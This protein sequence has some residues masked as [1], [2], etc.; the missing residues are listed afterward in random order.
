MAVNIYSVKCV[1]HPRTLYRGLYHTPPTK[2][3]KYAQ[4]QAPPL[5]LPPQQLDQCCVRD[6]YDTRTQVQGHAQLVCS[7]LME[8]YGSL[9][10]KVGM[11]VTSGPL[12]VSYQVFL[13][14]LC[15]KVTKPSCFLIPVL[16]ELIIVYSPT[17]ES[18]YAHCF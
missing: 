5:S 9:D 15:R 2:L 17:W 12:S 4:L 10:T 8:M 1:S 16:K 3:T 14:S 18:L 6:P 13:V 11:G 7:S